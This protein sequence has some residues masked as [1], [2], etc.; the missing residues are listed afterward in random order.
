VATVR[1]AATAF[2]DPFGSGR[3][4]FPAQSGNITNVTVTW[5]PSPSLLRHGTLTFASTQTDTNGEARATFL[6]DRERGDGRGTELHERG[7]VTAKVSAADIITQVYGQPSLGVLVPPLTKIGSMDV[8][9]GWHEP[10]TMRITITKNY[11]ATITDILGGGETSQKGKDVWTGELA[12]QDDLTWRGILTGTTGGS[13]S[14]KPPT[15]PVVGGAGCRWSWNAT[16]DFDVVAEEVIEGQFTL[17]FTPISRATGSMGGRKCRPTRFK[18]D[19]YVLA[20]FQDSRITSGLP[21][22]YV[23]PPRPGGIVRHDETSG[24]LSTIRLRNTYWEF[25]VEWVPP[26]PP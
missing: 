3:S 23:F 6:P 15:L 22:E 4:L 8:D 25:D 17:T 10:E 2:A 11:D 21:I 1:S 12:Q 13:G 5:E 7:Q 26:P 9:V 18:R 24:G 14:G 19:G 20:P 16:Q